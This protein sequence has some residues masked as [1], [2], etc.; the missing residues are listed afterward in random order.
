MFPRRLFVLQTLLTEAVQ[1]VVIFYKITG[2]YL[3]KLHFL[4]LAFGPHKNCLKCFLNN[5][6]A[7]RK[8]F[9][10]EFVP[11]FVASAKAS[12]HESSLAFGPHKNCLKA[13]FIQSS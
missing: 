7:W 6:Y 11:V 13:V 1:V 10:T 9:Q 3:R 8:C 2:N 4:T 12:Y 5:T